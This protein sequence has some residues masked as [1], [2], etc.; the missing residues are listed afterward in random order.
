MCLFLSSLIFIAC[1]DEPTKEEQLKLIQQ[2]W[3]KDTAKNFLDPDH[4]D[5]CLQDLGIK[6][7]LSPFTTDT[8]YISS[9]E[10]IS[11]KES[12]NTGENEKE[13]KMEIKVNGSINTFIA[14]IYPIARENFSVKHIY[15]FTKNKFGEWSV[16][17]NYKIVK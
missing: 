1:K 4:K 5:C 7:R 11:K 9:I 16:E 12:S 2:L 14:T 17:S 15:Y 8:A 13:F 10:I 6:N 3:N